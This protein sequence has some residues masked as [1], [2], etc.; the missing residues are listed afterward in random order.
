MTVARISFSLRP[1][2]I[3]AQ[4]HFRPVLRFHAARAGLDG[5]DGV[6]AV[7]FAGEQRDRF[8]FRDV[9]IGGVDLALGV[10]QERI[11]LRDVVLFLGQMEIG[12]M[13]LAM[14][15]SFS[16]AA[17]RLSA[18]LRCCKTFWA[19]SWSCQKSGCEVCFS[20]SAR[21]PRLRGTS[22]IAPHEFDSLPELLKAMFE[23]FDD[24]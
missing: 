1:A 21:I 14:R 23:I 13:S 5:H 22:K 7:V 16:S 6:E 8:Q 17:T 19:C 15:A 20:R 3:H 11:A 24:H 18:L 9:F 2:Q 12:S 10:A 4:Q